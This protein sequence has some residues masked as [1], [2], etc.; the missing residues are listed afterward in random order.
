MYWLVLQAL[1]RYIGECTLSFRNVALLSFSNKK[2]EERNEEKKGEK[3]EKVG[4]SIMAEC[5]E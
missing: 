4:S 2:K 1:Y 3:K 5:T